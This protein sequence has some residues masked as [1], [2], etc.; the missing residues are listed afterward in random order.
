MREMREG[1]W[2]GRR[3]RGKTCRKSVCVWGVSI[4]CEAQATPSVAEVRGTDIGAAR[5]A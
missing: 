5:L 1:V 4:G 2:E 3:G